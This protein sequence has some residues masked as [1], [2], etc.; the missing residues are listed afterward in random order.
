M[1][2]ELKVKNG[3]PD[4]IVC[5]D[6]SN[7]HVWHERSK[8]YETCAE[9]LT[10]IAYEPYTFRPFALRWLLL[11]VFLS[12]KLFPARCSAIIYRVALMRE[13]NASV[14]M[15]ICCSTAPALCDVLHRVALPIFFV[16]FVRFA[17]FFEILM[18]RWRKLLRMERITRCLGCRAA[19]AHRTRGILLSRQCGT[20]DYGSTSS[21]KEEFRKNR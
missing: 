3:I 18:G 9:Q 1:C 16:H 21:R 19:D 10:G 13:K 4:I 7:Q 14:L 15:R 12:K 2:R 5:K 20:I 17:S 6:M 11:S 8:N